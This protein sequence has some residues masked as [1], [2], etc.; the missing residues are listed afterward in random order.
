MAIKGFKFH[1]WVGWLTGT[2]FLVRPWGS[3]DFKTWSSLH[4][5]WSLI[6]FT[7]QQILYIDFFRLASDLEFLEVNGLARYLHKLMFVAAYLSFCIVRLVFLLYARTLSNLLRSLY[8][9]PIEKEMCNNWKSAWNKVYF[10]TS[11]TTIAVFLSSLLLVIEFQISPF[12][13]QSWFLP[14][15]KFGQAIIGFVF[16]CMTTMMATNIAFAA[17]LSI[18][19]HLGMIFS[20]FCIQIEERLSSQTIF[21]TNEFSLLNKNRRNTGKFLVHSP[22]DDNIVLNQFAVIEDLFRMADKILSPLAFVVI[23]SGTFRLVTGTHEILL[24]R[25]LSTILLL[26]NYLTVLEEII[27]TISMVLIGQYVKDKV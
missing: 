6:V 8:W 19:F 23:V 2:V 1:C 27:K 5:L 12:T 4:T 14:L 16:G 18:T 9:Y 13:I 11:V 15:G 17:I 25:K 10:T 7:I 24:N 22:W 26:G 3:P 20:D 21:F